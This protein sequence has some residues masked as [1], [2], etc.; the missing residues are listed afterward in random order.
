MAQK[1]FLARNSSRD[2]L[3]EK[4]TKKWVNGD[5]HCMHLNAI[6]MGFTGWGPLFRARKG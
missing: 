4:G 1:I 2:N 5:A 6:P 3:P